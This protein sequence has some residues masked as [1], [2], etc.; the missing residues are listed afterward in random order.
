MNDYKGIPMK[1]SLSIL[2][3]VVTSLILG[4][5][6]LLAQ[7]PFIKSTSETSAKAQETLTIQGI[8]F[9][10]DPNNI[11]VVFGGVSST[12]QTISD[13]LI[14][15][16]VP[17]GA[18]YGEIDVINTSVGLMGYSKDPFLQSYG[19]THPFNLSQVS[20]QNDFA[21]EA[22][23]YDLTTAD[24][25]GDGKMDVATSNT[26]ATH[27]NTSGISVFRNTGSPGTIS[28][29]KT[30]LTPGANTI[31]VTSGDLNGDGKPEIIVTEVNGSR[32][33]IFKNNSTVGSVSFAMQTLTV[34]GRQS[35]SSGSSRY[36][37]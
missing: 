7:V 22:G 33:F 5:F 16:S 8:N 28:F 18:A 26:D 21:S 13:Q 36:G 35:E 14:E 27:N 23:L 37:L 15:V 25:D 17:F 32:I 20:S 11:K 1:C 9:G 6:P 3:L 29:T 34:P 24:F 31:H 4:Q 10:T 12:P 30:V 19:G 2:Y